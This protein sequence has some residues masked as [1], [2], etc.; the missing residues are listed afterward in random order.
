MHRDVAKATVTLGNFSCNLSRN[1]VAGVEMF[2]T[3]YLCLVTG[4]IFFYLSPPTSNLN[5]IILITKNYEIC[6]FQCMRDKLQE[7][8]PSAT[9]P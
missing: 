3:V 8:L 7:K 5:N 6:L 9:A 4:R 2:Q 1:F